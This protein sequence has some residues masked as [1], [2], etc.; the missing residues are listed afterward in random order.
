MD[1]AA[2]QRVRVPKKTLFGP[3]NKAEQAKNIYAAPQ[4]DTHL[5]SDLRLVRK[6]Q[7]VQSKDSDITE[8]D[9]DIGNIVRHRAPFRTAWPR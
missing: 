9:K 5:Q 6:S 3:P 8:K 2:E 1:T 4:T 7:L